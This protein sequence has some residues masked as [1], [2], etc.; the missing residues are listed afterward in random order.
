MS[1]TCRVRRLAMLEY[2]VLAVGAFFQ[3]VCCGVEPRYDSVDMRNESD[4]I[5][6]IGPFGFASPDASAEH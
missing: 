6:V 1:L 2:V 5:G 4:C 3:T